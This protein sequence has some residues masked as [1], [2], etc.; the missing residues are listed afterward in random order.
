MRATAI[1]VDRAVT[2]ILRTVRNATSLQKES[3][4]K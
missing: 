3:P 4:F 1:T 2:M